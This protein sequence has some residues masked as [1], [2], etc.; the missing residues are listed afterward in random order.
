MKKI[1]GLD[2]FSLLM[3]I[4]VVLCAGLLGFEGL[5]RVRRPAPQSATPASAPAPAPA[6]QP[7]P[8]APAEQP[9]PGG[10]VGN[11]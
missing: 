7:Q 2:P 11:G 9:A 4:L 8:E 10:F 6:E 3:L 1:G 5:K